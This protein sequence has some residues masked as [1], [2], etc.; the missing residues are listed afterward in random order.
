MTMKKL[1]FKY[2]KYNKFMASCA[3]SAVILTTVLFS[4]V[5]IVGVGINEMTIYSDLKSL[6]GKEHIFI[7]NYEGNLNNALATLKSEDIVKDVDYRV[8]LADLEDENVPYS[9]EVACQN[10]TYYEYGF[11][12]IIKGNIPQQKNEVAIDE[13][14]LERLGY[15]EKVGKKI[16]LQFKSNKGVEIEE[17]VLSGVI[18]S[19]DAMDIKTGFVTV[20]TEFMESWLK[21]HVKDQIYGQVSIGIVLN[22]KKDVEDEAV[23]LI[24][25][26]GSVADETDYSINPVYES[27]AIK[28]GKKEGVAV[29]FLLLIICLTG[30]LLIYNIF[31]ISMVNNVKFYGLLKLIGASTKQISQY[32]YY[33]VLIIL[34]VALPIGVTAGF[35]MGKTILPFVL[36]DVSSEVEISEASFTATSIT[37]AIIIAILFSVFTTIISIQKPL[38]IAKRQPPLSVF[39]SEGNEIDAKAHKN[40]DGSKLYKFALFNVLRQKKQTIVLIASLALTMSLII[41]SATVLGS[42]SIEK[43]I[44]K[45]SYSDYAV[46]TNSYYK[47]HYDEGGYLSKEIV[48]CLREEGMIKDSG[49][50]YCICDDKE[51]ELT[52][53]QHKRDDY[54]LNIYGINEFNL[55]DNM[56]IEDAIDFKT[57]YEGRGVFEGTWGELGGS[58]AHYDIGETVTI[59]NGNGKKVD[60]VVIGHL[61][62]GSNLMSCQISGDD[63]YDLYISDSSFKRYFNDN[64]VMTYTFDVKPN[65]SEA[66]TKVARIVN[67]YSD[68]S[69][70]SKGTYVKEFQN[71]KDGMKLIG[72]ILCVVASFIALI[73]LINTLV[74]SVLS[75]KKE[76]ATLRSI[77]MSRGQ[78]KKMLLYESVYY[79][80]CAYIATVIVTV[81]MNN[82]FLKGFCNGF[83][84]MMYHSTLLP[85]LFV[86]MGTVLFAVIIIILIEK[87]ISKEDITCQIREL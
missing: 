65:S 58:D 71:L 45:V 18:Q 24:E 80:I 29:L 46:A 20:S 26:I 2:F 39:R 44:N 17:F 69:Y 40:T 1:A 7:K 37:S 62:L 9:V 8:Y 15:E 77:G 4:I 79:T 12:N 28:I 60:F 50:I 38:Q 61:D 66:E 21:E 74:M 22:N 78:L 68:A 11:Q 42:F 49:E 31:S 56:I 67:E 73:N 32:V 63:T 19:N 16:V 33:Y 82:T 36:R 70:R 13:E 59:A 14:T 81:I 3:I 48:D 76:I 54:W 34:S 41:I 51:Y 85:Y 55:R 53:T 6:G 47:Y 5:S 57:F 30:Y 23:K 10:A 75:R 25:K 43:Y 84:F 87:A 64:S 83:D 52:N 27:S 72:C 35:G 86:L